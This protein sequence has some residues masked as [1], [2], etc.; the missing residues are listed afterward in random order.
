MSRSYKFRDQTKLY[1]VSFAVVNW[2][3]VF[4]RREYKDVMVES[5]QYCIKHKGLE[6]YAWVIMSSHVHLIIGSTGEPMQGILRDMKRHTAKVILKLIE[7]HN[8][9]SRKEW[10]LW[11]FK[12]A[13]SRN[14]HTEIYQFWQHDNHPVEL[15]SNHLMQHKLDYLHQNPVEA[16]FVEEPWEYLYSSAR[17]YAGSKGL[18]DITLIE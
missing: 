15:S 1:F 8:Q 2:L 18:L 9:E 6:V 5:L 17:D 4:V 13:G 11:M 3:D 12:R 14:P 16:G 7:E 10:L